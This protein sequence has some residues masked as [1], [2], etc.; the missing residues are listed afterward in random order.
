MI[1]IKLNVFILW[2]QIIVK[3]AIIIVSFVL[4]LLLSAQTFASSYYGPTISNDRLYRI[5]LAL[6]PSPQVDVQ[7]VMVSIYERNSYAF[8]DN[9]I[10]GLYAGILLY[11]PS[12]EQIAQIDT[13]Y[14]HNLIKQ[15]NTAWQ[16]IHSKLVKTKQIKLK[17]SAKLD[18]DNAS[19]SPSSYSSSSQSHSAVAAPN[20]NNDNVSSYANNAVSLQQEYA[21]VAKEQASQNKHAANL[22]LKYDSEHTIFTSLDNDELNSAQETLVASDHTDVTLTKGIESTNAEKEVIY[23]PNTNTDIAKE[24][25]YKSIAQDTIDYPAAITNTTE[26]RTV[27]LNA[28][29]NSAKAITTDI[30]ASDL[31]KMQQQLAVLQLQLGKLLAELKSQQLNKDLHTTQGPQLSLQNK[32][33]LFDSSRLNA[34]NNNSHYTS[35]LINSDESYIEWVIAAGMSLVTLGLM[36]TTHRKKF[37]EIEVDMEDDEYDYIGSADGIP[38][39]LNLAKA[40]CEMGNGEKAKKTLDEVIAKG[41]NSQQLEAKELLAEIEENEK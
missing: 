15:H 21:D 32:Y 5:A 36:I 24:S 19:V 6:Q 2:E 26:A 27:M 22:Q 12:L 34:E 40:Y 13:F 10:N 38:V 39:K 20:S 37:A 8:I 4:T 29:T 3:K 18:S 25:G 16:T 9:N 7:Q 41:T 23:S 33:A 35:L 14:A 28:D 30:R 1:G 17:Q 31:Y 11:I